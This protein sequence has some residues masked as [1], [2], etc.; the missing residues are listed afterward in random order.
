MTNKEIIE[1]LNGLKESSKEEGGKNT[2]IRDCYHSSF[3]FVIDKAIQALEQTHWIPMSERMPEEK[4]EI[5]ACFYNGDGD[6][7]LM[8]TYRTDYNY[9]KGVGRTGDMVAWMP[10]PQPYEPQESEDDNGNR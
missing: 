7:K 3:V 10:L 2:L 4:Q 6:Y 8:V 9:W 5:L 1:M